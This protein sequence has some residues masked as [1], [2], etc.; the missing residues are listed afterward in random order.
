MNFNIS[1]KL[2]QES[3]RE[4]AYRV[5]SNN[6]LNMNLIPGTALSEQDIAS[7]LE[8]SRTPVREAFIRL[9]QENLLDILPQKGTYVAKIDLEQVAEAR[10]LRETM[11]FAIIKIV[12]REFSQEALLQLQ[13]CLDLQELCVANEDYIKFFELDEAMHG[14]IFAASHKARIWNMIKQMSL[15]YNRVRMLNLTKGYYELPKLFEQHQQI[16]DA[17][18]QHDH[19]VGKKVIGMHINK[20]ITDI[21]KL[22]QSYEGYFK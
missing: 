10:F 5:L 1:D 12:C 7:L 18:I 19:V 17:I 11:E 22:K 14:L 16:V 6:I 13:A 20:V 9:A 21:E 4:Y 3:I 8:I 15:N 2:P